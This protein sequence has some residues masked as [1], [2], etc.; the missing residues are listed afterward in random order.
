MSANLH[1]GRP[2]HHNLFLLCGG[3]RSVHVQGKQPSTLPANALCSTELPVS[4]ANPN[5]TSHLT[6]PTHE[7]KS[8]VP[9]L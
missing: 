9:D 7:P 1:C 5:T 4:A 8:Q 6:R 3:E 2:R